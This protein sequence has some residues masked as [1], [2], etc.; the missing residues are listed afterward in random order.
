MCKESLQITNPILAIE[1]HHIKNGKLTPSDIVAGSYKKA[2]WQC[3]KDKEHVWKA[4]IAS[5]N[6]GAGCPYCTGRNATKLNNLAATH[7]ELVAQWHST[8]NGSL[9]PYDVKAGSDKR[10]WWKC[11]EGSDHEWETTIS[12]RKAGT[13]CPI[14]AG[15][16]VVNSNS[17]KFI[18]PSLSKQWHPI[19]NGS[20]TPQDVT[21]RTS[22]KV[23]WKCPEGS[24][25][26]WEAS[27]SSR[28]N[29]G[30]CPYCIGRKG[31]K[32]KNFSRSNPELAK[33]WHP[34]KNGSLSP[35]DVT[36]GSGKKVW[37]KCPVG[38]DHEWY[39]T[40]YSRVKGSGCPFCSGR[41]ASI[42]NNLA[43]KN[44]ELTNQ[45]HPSKNGD[46]TPFD[47]LPSTNQ[48]IW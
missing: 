13:K 20:L 21:A 30:D 47:V 19:K 37:W 18:N 9:T 38:S 1:W 23:W 31:S 3:A 7:P 4:T 16:K 34:T 41:R 17:L 6:R 10:V 29:G 33:Q 40:I 12:N 25:H 42:T 43:V 5:R 28:N 36:A 26:E 46:L 11:R 48:M 14:C 32:S 44:P 27:I 15:K 35:K 45:W 24:D 8:K 22:R 39:V 2:W